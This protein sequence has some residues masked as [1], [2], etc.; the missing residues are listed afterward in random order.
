MFEK[1]DVPAFF[2]AK[3]AVLTAFSQG[4][5]QGLIVDS[6]ATYTSATPVY[7]GYALIKN[8]VKSEVGG[9]LVMEQCRRMLAEQ[10]IELVPYYK[11]ASKVCSCIV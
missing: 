9:D 10:N 5:S 6:G 8:H 2:I 3:T 1:Y 11:I 7:E 4:R